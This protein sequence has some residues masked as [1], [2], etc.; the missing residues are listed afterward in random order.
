[1]TWHLPAPSETLRAVRRSEEKSRE[2][3][4]EKLTRTRMGEEEGAL[5]GSWVGEGRN[6]KGVREWGER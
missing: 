2:V 4:S 5:M 1:M 3:P 6:G